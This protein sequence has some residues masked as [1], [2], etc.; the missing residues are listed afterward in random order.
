[1]LQI[2][3]GRLFKKSPG[4]RNELRGV[5]YTNLQIYNQVIETAAGRLL[6][7]SPLHGSKALVYEFTELIEDEPGLGAIA[8]HGIDPYLSDFAAIVSFA[9]NVTCTPDQDLTFRLLR[10]WTGPSVQRPPRDLVPRVFDD[11]VWC[12]PADAVRL[13]E[14]VGQLISLE[15]RS[16]R[17]AMRAVRSYVTGMHR[18]VDDYELAYTLLVVSMESLAQEFDD[19]D[20]QWEDYDQQKRTAIDRALAGADEDLAARVR[21]ALLGTEHVALGR[22]FREYVLGNL[23]SSYFRDEARGVTNPM[24]HSDLDSALRQAYDLR[25]KYV[26]RLGQLPDMLT[27]PGLGET[28]SLP[29]SNDVLPTFQGLARLARHVITTFIE[30]QPKVYREDYDYSLERVGILLA[31]LAPQYW[32]GGVKDLDV[33]SGRRRLEGFLKQA[34]DY[35][36]RGPQ[37]SVVTDLRKVLTRVERMLPQMNAEQQRPFVA[38]YVLFNL[39]VLGDDRMAN[40]DTIVEHY[41]HELNNPTVE[42]MLTLLLLNIVPEWSLEKH[43]EIHDGYF[44]QKHHQHGLRVPATLE[45]GLSLSLAERYRLAGNAQQ[46]WALV[47]VAVENHPG[48]VPLHELEQNF[49]STREINWMSTLS[50][51]RP[52]GDST[53]PVARTGVPDAR[54]TT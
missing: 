21:A 13:F 41:G 30:K 25:S 20:P 27:I 16:F 28:A 34:T 44:R 1:M 8:S 10:G 46:A 6:S 19:F 49:D 42:A 36:L 7:T 31:E 54:C 40:Y 23:Q 29:L 3:S 50:L 43:Q 14:L 24:G 53:D 12:Q 38:L 51:Q 18:L 15:R 35:L 33:A 11:M 26:H 52:D 22:R 47:T 9:L 32:V 4:Q 48:H 2:A 17:A 5:L 37:S 39:M 45:T